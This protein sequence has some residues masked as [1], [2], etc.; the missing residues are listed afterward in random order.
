MKPKEDPNAK[1]ARLREMRMSEVELT[2]ATQNNAAGLTTDLRSI[3]GMNGGAGGMSL[4]SLIGQ[5]S[6][7]KPKTGMG[8]G[9]DSNRRS[10]NG[11]ML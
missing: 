4:F 9:S 8:R 11:T 3:Y 7:S 2:K 1:A 6:A 10:A 5:S